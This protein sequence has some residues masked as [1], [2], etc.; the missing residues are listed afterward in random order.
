M[1]LQNQWH[2]SEYWRLADKATSQPSRDCFLGQRS[3]RPNA[4]KC[5]KNS[6]PSSRSTKKNYKRHENEINQTIN[7]KK[8]LMVGQEWK[9][10]NNGIPDG[11]SIFRN[12][13][14]ENVTY[15]GKTLHR[16]HQWFFSLAAIN[17]KLMENLKEKMHTNL[18]LWKTLMVGDGGKA[19]ADVRGWR[20]SIHKSKTNQNFRG[21]NPSFI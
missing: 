16:S 10:T 18:E 6:S 4:T 19:G 11:R 5:C 2:Y 13:E 14:T 7:C 1:K 9:A 12:T 20:P 8:G 17:L 21:L 15:F 3:I